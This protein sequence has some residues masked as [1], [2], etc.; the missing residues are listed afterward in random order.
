MSKRSDLLIA[1]IVGAALSLSAC[2]PVQMTHLDNQPFEPLF[3]VALDQ[4]AWLAVDSC[5]EGV[6]AIV[7]LQLEMEPDPSTS[8][9]PMSPIGPILVSLVYDKGRVAPLRMGMVEGPFCLPSSQVNYGMERSGYLSQTPTCTYYYRVQF[10]LTHVP[11][12]SEDIY[13]RYGGR[14]VRFAMR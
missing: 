7:E 10:D 4:T 3:K 1:S 5:D 2:A 9:Q 6:H 12:R 13:L 14:S 11:D 8:V